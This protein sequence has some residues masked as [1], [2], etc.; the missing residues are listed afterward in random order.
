VKALLIV[1]M[2][3]DFMPGGP[4][5]VPGA[6]QLIPVINALIPMFPLVVAS[7][8]FHPKD[9]VSFASNHL[10]KKP[11]DHI[12]VGNQDQVLWPV[13][14]VGNSPG[15]ELVAS[16]DKT[17]ITRCFPKGTDQAIDSYSAFFDNAR[18]KATGLADYLKSHRVTDLYIVGVATDYCVLYSSLD[19]LD[20]GFN[21][22]VIKEGCK[23]INLSPRDEELA[24][25]A[26][27][28]RGGTLV[29]LKL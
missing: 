5:G 18:Q 20:L 13:H 21:V 7:Q 12:S 1:D 19:A 17:N 14:C 27:T 9:H 22:Y 23:A 10:G 26:I 29:D 25:A 28:A 3:N 11:G 24:F 15:A 2:Q 6:D 4:L 16:L 8:D